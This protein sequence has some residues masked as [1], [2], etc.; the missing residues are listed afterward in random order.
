MYAPVFDK[1]AD[2]LGIRP[3]GPQ[4][5]VAS[6]GICAPFAPCYDV[7]TLTDPSPVSTAFP[8]FSTPRGAISYIGPPGT[9]YIAPKPPNGF[10]VEWRRLSGW[11]KHHRLTYRIFRDRVLDTKAVWDGTKTA[12]SDDE[13]EAMDDW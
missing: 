13:I 5:L 3:I 7:F 11:Y 12:F 8:H 10:Q 2:Q 4:G 1:L 6:G 9:E